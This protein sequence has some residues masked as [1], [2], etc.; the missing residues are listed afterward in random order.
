MFKTKG[1]NCYT[2][3]H[4]HRYD[5]DSKRKETQRNK[6]PSFFQKINPYKQRCI[7]LN[8]VFDHEII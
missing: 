1:N 6:S 5:L 4:R 8:T 7:A 3:L 2:L